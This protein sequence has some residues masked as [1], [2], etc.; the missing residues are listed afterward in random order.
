M[1]TIALLVEKAVDEREL[2]RAWQL[3]SRLGAAVQSAGDRIAASILSSD[4]QRHY[5]ASISA[6]EWQCECP[7]F[8]KSRR[9]AFCKHL[10]A[11]GVIW[12][13]MNNGGV[14]PDVRELAPVLTRLVTSIDES[15]A[16]SLLLLAAAEHRDVYDAIAESVTIGQ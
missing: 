15:T 3:A 10:G 4:G 9:R 12:L 5:A 11:L 2:L 1:V 8:E 13:A 7:A 16:R 14:A 6:A